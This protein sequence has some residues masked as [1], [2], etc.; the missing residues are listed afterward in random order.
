MQRVAGDAI[1]Q[2]FLTWHQRHV[3]AEDVVNVER[4][5]EKIGLLELRTRSDWDELRPLIREIYWSFENCD[6]SR[7]STAQQ[8]LAELCDPNESPDMPL[9]SGQRLKRRHQ[10]AEIVVE[11]MLECAPYLNLES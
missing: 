6:R 8:E 9:E 4:I 10:R 1:D 7:Y 5:L 11:L 2:L 3:G